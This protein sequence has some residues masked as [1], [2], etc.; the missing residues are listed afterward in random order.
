MKL[1]HVQTLPRATQVVTTTR[2]TEQIK[3]FSCKALPPSA[4]PQDGQES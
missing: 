1:A 2:K 3:T 4:E